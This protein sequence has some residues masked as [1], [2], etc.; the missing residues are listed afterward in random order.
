LSEGAGPDQLEAI[1]CA[2]LGA[3]ALVTAGTTSLETAGAELSDAA[4][5]TLGG[6]EVALVVSTS[7]HAIMLVASSKGTMR[8]GRGRRRSRSTARG[9]GS[10][11]EAS[12]SDIAADDSAQLSGA[13]MHGANLIE[14]SLVRASSSSALCDTSPTVTAR[15]GDL[16]RPLGAGAALACRAP[17][18]RA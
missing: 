3:V 10:T 11:V 7:A 2:E 18:P 6:A 12:I 9:A 16:S 8:Q 4:V 15:L 14:A 13:N 1:D 17:A 5:V